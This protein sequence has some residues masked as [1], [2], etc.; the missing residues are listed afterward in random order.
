MRRI[1]R[2]LR[3][4]SSPTQSS[5]WP[6][7][8]EP[9]VFS[10]GI[11]RIRHDGYDASPVDTVRSGEPDAADDPPAHSARIAMI[12]S[13]RATRRDGSQLDTRLTPAS[14]AATPTNVAGSHGRTP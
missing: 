9:C 2:M 11:R 7:H 14:S 8:L 4:R 3:I 1:V 5:S 6:G 12:G 10:E 13:T